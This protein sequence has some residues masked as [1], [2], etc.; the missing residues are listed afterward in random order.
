MTH[1]HLWGS[2]MDHDIQGMPKK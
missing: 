1:V 2:T